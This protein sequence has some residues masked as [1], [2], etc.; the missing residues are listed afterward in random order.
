VLAAAA[1]VAVLLTNGGD[2]H[3]TPTAAGI[4]PVTR[5]P[6]QFYPLLSR[7]QWTSRPIPGPGTV[8]S[9]DLTLAP[10]AHA[11]VAFSATGPSVSFSRNAAGAWSYAAGPG[12]QNRALPSVPG[13]VGGGTR[14]VEAV[15]GMTTRVRVDGRL[16]ASSAAQPAGDE[17]VSLRAQRGSASAHDV[18]ISAGSDRAA[19]LLHRLT[20]LH[21]RLRPG[22]RLIG[23]DRGDHLRLGSD[24]TSGFWAGALWQA[25]ALQPKG[26]VFTRWALDATVAHFGLER[27]LTHDQGFMY[28]QS[29]LAAWRAR[30]RFRDS[31]SRPRICQRLVHS[32][33]TAADTLVA[34][35][36]TNPG[37]GTIPT[38]ATSPNGESIIDSM[39]NLGILTWASRYTHRRAYARLASHQAHVVGSLLVRQD[40]S[41]YQAVHFDRQTGKIVF[42]G[43]HQGLSDSSTWARGEG[44]GLYG[45]AQT[46]MDLHDRSLLAIAQRMG[47]YISQHLPDDGVPRWDYA[48]GS[49]ARVDV[50]AGTIT[51]AGM[52]RLA[53]ACHRLRGVCADPSQWVTLGRTML[54]RSLAYAS[55][56]PPLG[57]LGS[58]VLN[59]RHHG[60][61][62]NGGELIFG[63]T[64]ALEA[65]NLERTVKS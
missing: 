19:L 30:C 31:A 4:A 55:A 20:E 6:V 23:A 40:G 5:G 27:A 52:F 9:L 1:V 59:A 32:V 25:A 35:A 8:V 47:Q 45:F 17:R 15:L 51:A 3:P 38:N 16:L 29:S 33:L 24:W 14:H 21:A 36:N 54:A 39:M 43:T 61:W 48:A 63:L 11:A 56:R 50:S 12:E 37:A 60:C 58:Q 44:W 53:L 57:F 34:L 18:L 49:H 22:D 7:A 28:G 62:C 46:A 2:T 64:Y 10:G 41:S 13:W 42:I 65:L 26:G